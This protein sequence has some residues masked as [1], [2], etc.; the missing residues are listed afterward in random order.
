MCVCACF[1]LSC[2][3]LQGGFT[4]LGL[5][6]QAQ[7]ASRG[8][9]IVALVPSL[10]AP[11]VQDL[12]HL[13]RESTNNELIYAEECDVLNPRSVVDF[14]RTWYRGMKQSNKSNPLAAGGAGAGAGTGAGPTHA[15]A[16][17]APTADAFASSAGETSAIRLDAIVFL[18]LVGTA[19]S[20]G[21]GIQRVGTYPTAASAAPPL[22]GSHSTQEAS[23]RTSAEARQS[24]S[25]IPKSK[26]D[27]NKSKGQKEEDKGATK[28]DTPP[29]HGLELSHA[30]VAA[31]YHFI[32]SMLPS[33]RLLPPDRDV[34]IIS[35]VSPWASTGVSVFSAMDPDW[36]GATP[37]SSPSHF[38]RWQPWCATG[39]AALR[40][41]ALSSQL[42]RQIDFLQLREGRGAPA[43]PTAQ[44]MDEIDVLTS[45]PSSNVRL[46]N[47]CL[48]FERNHDLIRL[49]LPPPPPETALVWEDEEV[50]DEKQRRTGVEKQE[51][52]VVEPVTG[53]TQDGNEKESSSSS[54]TQPE[55]GLGGSKP[56]AGPEPETAEQLASQLKRAIDPRRGQAD[57]LP[58]AW[59]KAAGPASYTRGTCSG[60]EKALRYLLALL[61]WPLLW[62]TTKAPARAGDGVTWA[63]TAPVA[64]D[65]AAHATAA[66]AA[67]EGPHPSS[68]MTSRAARPKTRFARVRPV[69]LF[70][71]NEPRAVPSPPGAQT[72]EER[73]LLAQREEAIIARWLEAANANASANVESVPQ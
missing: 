14:A 3:F 17:P 18:P 53:L 13:L 51:G 72:E 70:R 33:I 55:P 15:S 19:Y 16:G 65:F 10:S 11:D 46:V 29:F 71:E 24:Q 37:T 62:L 43:P 44:E 59:G 42:Q 48:G 47:V 22:E 64:N 69:V 66:A 63:L 35:V 50:V 61:L 67:A 30:E 56:G 20:V 28:T 26:H 8:A 21:E 38:P 57:L 12:T 5:V 39:S 6:V 73:V 25:K 32:K 40:W 1:S 9:Q 7:L 60:W 36:T 27:K 58:A 2:R 34:R 45:A 31:R 54:A 52:G 68:S 4:P 23:E 41:L 49:I